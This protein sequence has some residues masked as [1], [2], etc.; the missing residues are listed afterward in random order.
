MANQWGTPPAAPPPRR[1]PVAL[2]V[3][4]SVAGALVLCCGGGLIFAAISNGASPAGPRQP[5][6]GSPAQPQASVV[7]S[8]PARSDWEVVGK[9][10]KTS[11]GLMLHAVIRNNTGSDWKDGGFV[12]L[13]AY[14]GND[15]QVGEF[16]GATSSTI[17]NGKTGQVDLFADS[18][19]KQLNLSTVKRWEVR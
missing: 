15:N 18:A 17:Y 5:A 14:D 8:S 3:I 7:P 16:T 9:P 1:R 2:I 13:T 6:A 4:L 11:G 19:G 10:Y 12:T